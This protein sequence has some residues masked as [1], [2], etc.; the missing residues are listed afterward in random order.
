MLNVHKS[1]ATS[2]PDIIAA[3][4]F[5]EKVGI[6]NGMT[7]EAIDTCPRSARMADSVLICSGDSISIY[8]I[9]DAFDHSKLLSIVSY[10]AEAP[11]SA[12]A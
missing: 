11:S 6:T 9:T 8:S 7:T 5:S 4:A 2:V 3:S 1:I 10:M 12:P